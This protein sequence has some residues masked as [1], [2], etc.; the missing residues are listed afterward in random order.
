MKDWIPACLPA[1]QAF[2][3]MTLSRRRFWR[4]IALKQFESDVDQGSGNQQQRGCNN[5]ICIEVPKIKGIHTTFLSSLYD[6]IQNRI[7]RTMSPVKSA[8]SRMPFIG[9]KFGTTT[10][11]PNQPAE[12]FTASADSVRIAAFLS[13]AVVKTCIPLIASNAVPAVNET[14]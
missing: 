6:N 10:S 7:P 12:R 9:K 4:R 13:F 2:A 1:R 5:S 3:G 14:L 11:N 8:I